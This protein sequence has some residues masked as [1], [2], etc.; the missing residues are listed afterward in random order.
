MVSSPNVVPGDGRDPNAHQ[1]KQLRQQLATL[2]GK[3]LTSISVT[4]ANGTRLFSIANSGYVDS[5][6]NPLVSVTLNDPISGCPIIRQAPATVTSILS[7]LSQ[8][9]NWFW[10]MEDS[11]AD[12]VIATDGLSGRGLA[13]PYL[14]VPMYPY[15]NGGFGSTAGSYATIA[16]SAIASNTVLWEGRIGYVSHP[17]I[18]VDGTWGR[19]SGT[20]AET[21]TYT[22][23]VN[24]SS[25]GTWTATGLVVG[26][27]IFD[28][29]TLVGTADATVQLAAQSSI[30]NTDQIACQVLGVHLR[31]TPPSFG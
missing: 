24:G 9:T 23:T 4:N 5:S 3:P 22:L 7:G 1:I 12:Q 15:W 6:G 21:I 10:Y 19:G 13:Y 25:V 31:Q 27:H 30:S 17:A 26:K 29:H 11:N 18:S 8:G 20:G 2:A 14:A 16:A 28:I